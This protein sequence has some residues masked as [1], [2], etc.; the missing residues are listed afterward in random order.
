MFA[1]FVCLTLSVA[2]MPQQTNA[3]SLFGFDF[4]PLF[5]IFAN[6]DKKEEINKEPTEQKSTVSTNQSSSQPSTPR[7]PR[8]PRPEFTVNIAGTIYSE[9]YIREVI[10]T[11]DEFKGYVQKFGYSCVGITTDQGTEFT[12]N[13]NVDRGTVTSVRSGNNCD[14]KISFREELITQIEEE[15]FRASSLM[16]YL[17]KVDIPSSVYFKALRVVVS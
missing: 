4:S 9:S 1:I 13:F 3:F 6:K 17:G 12:L 11:N 2:V 5:S 15:G 14:L 16:S 7:P 8:P 10:N